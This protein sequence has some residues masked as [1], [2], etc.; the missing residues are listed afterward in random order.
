M[1]EK[2]FCHTHELCDTNNSRVESHVRLF[3]FPFLTDDARVWHLNMKRHKTDRRMKFRKKQ[4]F[5]LRKNSFFDDRENEKTFHS[6]RIFSTLVTRSITK[7]PMG[8]EK[9][10]SCLKRDCLTITFSWASKPKEVFFF[11]NSLR[12]R[13][14]ARGENTS[15]PFRDWHSLSLSIW[16]KMARRSDYRVSCCA[17]CEGTTNQPTPT[18][19]PTQLR[20]SD[21]FLLSPLRTERAFRFITTDFRFS[22]RRPEIA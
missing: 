22:F 20:E 10:R 18:A 15:R 2:L 13:K 14:L 1:R 5:L 19:L 17:S 9:S 12:K 21:E 6:G 4:I 16:R 8:G 7:V 11:R 3:L